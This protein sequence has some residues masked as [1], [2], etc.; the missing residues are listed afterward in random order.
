MDF[1]CA[2]A[3][4]DP[5]PAADFGVVGDVWLTERDRECVYIDTLLSVIVDAS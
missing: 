1:T 3:H 4:A 2:D 5:N